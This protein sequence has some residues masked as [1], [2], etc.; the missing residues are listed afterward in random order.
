[1]PKRFA[2]LGIRVRADR[3]APCGASQRGIEVILLLL[4]HEERQRRGRCVPCLHLAGGVDRRRVI[5]G[6]EARLELSEPVVT[7]QESWGWLTCRALL[8]GA[9]GEPTIVERTELRG[10]STQHP[11]ERERRGNS[12]EEESEPPHERQSV[13]GLALELIEWMAQGKMNG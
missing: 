4:Q 2:M 8:E 1:S 10:P 5:A 11:G 6:E 3:L 12:V 7:F 9:L 13:L